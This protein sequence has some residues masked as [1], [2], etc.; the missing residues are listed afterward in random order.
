MEDE[1]WGVWDEVLSGVGRC[2][3]LDE[4]C[5]VVEKKVGSG[6]HFVSCKKKPFVPSLDYF[7]S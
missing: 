1:S 2:R 6:L 3:L 7:R 5:I 4:V